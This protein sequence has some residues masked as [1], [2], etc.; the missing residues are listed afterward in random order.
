VK[1]GRNERDDEKRTKE[2]EEELKT[3]QEQLRCSINVNG[4]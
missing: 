3:Q 4:T 2:F 1:K